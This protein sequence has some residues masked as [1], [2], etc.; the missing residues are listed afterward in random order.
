MLVKNVFLKANSVP[1][2]EMFMFEHIGV[3]GFKWP[4]KFVT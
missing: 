4:T 2:V 1:K 3:N